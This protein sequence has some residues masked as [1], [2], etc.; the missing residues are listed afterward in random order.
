MRRVC[1]PPA[2]HDDPRETGAT[3]PTRARGIVPGLLKKFGP[4]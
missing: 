3:G 1:A 4:F 2:A